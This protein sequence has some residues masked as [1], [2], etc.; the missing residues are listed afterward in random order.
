[1]Q[2]DAAPLDAV[3]LTVATGANGSFDLHEDASEDSVEDSAANGAAKSS[4]MTTAAASAKAT[5]GSASTAV[6]YTQQATGGSLAI[7]PANGS[8]A[9]QVQDRSWTAT[10]TNADRPRTV[11]I[12]GRVIADTAWTYD[13]DTR[14]ISVPV[15]ERSVTKR[16]V[17][18]FSSKAAATPVLQVES[19]RVDAGDTQT[20]TGTGFPADTNV[21]LAT[22]PRIGGAT[23]HTDAS[24]AFSTD[25]RVPGTA[26]GRVTV[27]ASVDGVA[28]ARAAFTVV[29][30]AAP[31][32]T[33]SPGAGTPGSGAPT[34]GDSGSAAPGAAAPGNGGA[35]AGSD[36][37]GALA[38]TG[39]NLL[40]LGLLA[41]ALL[42]AGGLVWT[43]RSRRR[44][45]R[46]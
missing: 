27:T 3:T 7:A 21:T 20:L 23:A 30:A 26:S 18:A 40:P 33:T 15:D 11:T 31:A 17:V 36:P 45:A 25:L 43:L 1:V 29:A 35:D 4:A 42:A 28:L 37:G 34:P 8:F 5:A 22:A 2:N 46:V 10:F 16:T 19:P 14:T 12:D 39:A 32:P 38:W 41:A 9:G 44:R 6:R 24:G 13:S